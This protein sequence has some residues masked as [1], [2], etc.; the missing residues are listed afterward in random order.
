MRS[1]PSEVNFS[2]GQLLQ[3]N[4]S[5]KY[6]YLVVH[7]CTT[8]MVVYSPVWCLIACRK[9]LPLIVP[10]LSLWN[11]SWTSPCPWLSFLRAFALHSQTFASLFPWVLLPLR[12]CFFL[13]DYVHELIYV[14]V[15]FPNH[16]LQPWM[17]TFNMVVCAGTF[18]I[19]VV[20]LVELEL[21]I[22]LCVVKV[23]YKAIY[24]R[25]LKGFL[26]LDLK[27]A[28]VLTWYT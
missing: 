10:E 4:C 12:G 28:I 19:E 27:Q 3:I 15:S 14:W 22:D 8:P 23:V 6:M 24:L 21:P 11:S 1:I 5:N 25:K 9:P 13:L 7:Y 17:P 26:F 18:Q 16:F 20:P 2:Q